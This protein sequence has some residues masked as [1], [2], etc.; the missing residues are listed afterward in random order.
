M[1]M[2]VLGT[3][4]DSVGGA[5][6]HCG[7]GGH[8]ASGFMHGAWD[9]FPDF[10]YCNY[11][12]YW[13]VNNGHA[14]GHAAMVSARQVADAIER[15]MK[16]VVF[17]PMCNYSSAKATEWIPIIPGTDAAVILAMTNV[18]V[19]D[20][21]VWDGEYLKKKTNAPY[22]VGPDG[23]FVRDDATGKPLVFDPAS[24]VARPYDDP[25]IGDYALV[26]RYVARGIDC[27][28]AFEVIREHLRG[29]SPE[30][31]SS[32]SSVPA[33]TIRRIAGEYAA[34][35]RIGETITID[36]RTLPFRPV[37]SSIFRG[38]EGHGNAFHTCMA[39]CL[40]TH[41]LGAADVPGGAVG[42]PNTC[43]GYP[44]TGRPRF[45]VIQGPD[46]MLS[47]QKFYAY[48]SPWP[49][50][51]PKMP[52]EPA[53]KELFRLASFSPV[54]AVPEAERV[55]EAIGL[56]VPYRGHAQL[57]LQLAPR[58]GKPGDARRLFEEDT[59]HRRFQHFRQR[60]LRGLRR[61]PAAGHELL[62]DVHVDRRPGLQP[63]LPLRDGPMVLS[64]P[65]ACSQAGAFTALHHGCLLRA[66][67]P[68]RK[69][70]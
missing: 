28:P 9:I 18:I 69:E 54:W 11:A 37:A 60:V 56:P 38:G 34:A 24:S 58:D 51:E 17:D 63:Q 43:F 3:P 26:G 46:G 2:T 7:N 70:G 16:L 48:S 5:G 49:I 19:N 29:Y 47:L 6:L 4:N 57:R 15:G 55:W 32:V 67:R 52:T 25:D 53:L 35:A 42:M 23:R 59:V 45:N 40:M 36:G 14:T 65:A 20:L 12:I 64:H 22:L 41:V 50:K 13:G 39:M 68:H 44:E 1:M 10:R 27:R 33:E 66:L 62:R 31:A 30:M 61:H 21:K 8:Y